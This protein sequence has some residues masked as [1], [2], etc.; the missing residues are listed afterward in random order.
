ME[1]VL[2]S[3]AEAIGH[4]LSEPAG[5]RG[6]HLIPLP[7]DG[8]T[9]LGFYGLSHWA[10][11]GDGLLPD[12]CGVSLIVEEGLELTCAVFAENG[13][14]IDPEPMPDRPPGQDFRI[15]LRGVGQAGISP[16]TCPVHG[17]SL[18]FRFTYRDGSGARDVI[19]PLEFGEPVARALSGRHLFFQLRRHP[20]TLT[21]PHAGEQDRPPTAAPPVSAPARGCP[22]GADAGGPVSAGARR[23]VPRRRGCPSRSGGAAPGRWSSPGS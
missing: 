20:V 23:R 16:G 19:L 10:A 4:D 14:R 8:E 15:L 9:W 21:G 17:T 1:P 18:T 12:G 22:P 5:H 2:P 11:P 3:A 13:E 7:V 6:R